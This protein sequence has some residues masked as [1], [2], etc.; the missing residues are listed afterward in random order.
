[1]KKHCAWSVYLSVGLTSVSLTR[2]AVEIEPQVVEKGANHRVWQKFSETGAPIGSYVELASG[3]HYWDG[4]QWADSREEIEIVEGGALAQ[5]GPHKV[6]FAANANTLGA[7]DFVSSD[8][9]R[10]RS[11]VLGLAYTCPSN[12]F[13]RPAY[14]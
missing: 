3:L 1:M 5:R 12:Q 14:G 9:K 8:N 2:A 13:M 11:H 10:L 6:G 7:I 4:V